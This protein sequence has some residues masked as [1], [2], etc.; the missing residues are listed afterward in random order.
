VGLKFGG[1]VLDT[2]SSNMDFL[3]LKRMVRRKKSATAKMPEV[4]G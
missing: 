2:M 4:K 3:D 1:L